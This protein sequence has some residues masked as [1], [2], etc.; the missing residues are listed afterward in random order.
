MASPPKQKEEDKVPV[1]QVLEKAHYFTQALVP[2]PGAVPYPPL[3][4]PSALRLRTRVVALTHNNVTY[5]ALGFLVHW[6]D[7]HPLPAGGLTPTPEYDDAE[8]YGRVSA[9]GY[10]E[11][12]GSTLA[13]G[14]QKGDFVYGYLPLAT[15]AQDVEFCLDDEVPGHL[16]A[17]SAYRAKLMPFYNHYW[18]VARDSDAAKQLRAAVTDHDNKQGTGAT[19]EKIDDGLGFDSLYRLLFEC[20]HLVT[21]YMFDAQN[22]VHPGMGPDAPRKSP[23]TREMADLAGATVVLLAPASKTALGMAYE[24][25]K[26]V[27]KGP[28]TSEPRRVVGAAGEGSREFVQGTG[29]YNVTVS[30]SETPDEAFLKT[31]LGVDVGAG[32]KVVLIDCGGRAGVGAKWAAAFRTLCAPGRFVMVG[33]GSEAGEHSPADVLKRFAPKETETETNEQKK[34]VPWFMQVNTGDL[35]ERAAAQVGR[36]QVFDSAEA[37]FAEFKRDGVAGFSV[38]WGEGME[39]VAEGWERLAKGQTRAEEGMAFLL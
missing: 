24:M 10:A 32:E 5:A 2:V 29:L 21:R 9:W 39:A 12:L 36:Q 38:R 28:A 16:Q 27:K 23:W 35:R 8:K 11:V 26:R 37:A 22:P 18:A 1:M 3:S 34:E 7:A 25:Q 13:G 33:I 20:G 14:P 6:W 17:T 15:L 31:K 19:V 30:T 4:A